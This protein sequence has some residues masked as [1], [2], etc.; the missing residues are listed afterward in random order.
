MKQ[1]NIN[2]KKSEYFGSMSGS[3]SAFSMKKQQLERRKNS[4]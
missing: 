4:F 2:L 1:Q 3:V